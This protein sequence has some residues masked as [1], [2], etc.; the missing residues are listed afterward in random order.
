MIYILLLYPIFTGYATVRSNSSGY[1]TIECNGNETK[2]E[3]C[4]IRK[5]IRQTCS[6]TA[7]MI[8]C[9]RCKICVS[10]D[11]HHSSSIHMN[12]SL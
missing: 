4:D 10:D 6:S 12:K 3:E 7:V 8:Y 1:G 9:F 2:L 11:K 5:N